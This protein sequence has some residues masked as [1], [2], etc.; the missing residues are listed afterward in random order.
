MSDRRILLVFA[1]PDDESFA[2]GITIAKYAALPNTQ[3][4]LLCA[5]RGEAGKP[6]N[7]PICTV[8]ELPQVREQE[9]LEASRILGID[10]VEILD[11]QDKQVDTVPIEELV[12]QITAA[13]HRDQP[14]VVITFAP[15]G[16]SGHPDHR[17][18][19]EAT[20]VAVQTIGDSSVRKLYHVTLPSTEPFIGVK[21]IHT[22]P[23]DVITTKI[24]CEECV[25]TVAHALLAHR[26]QHLSVDRVFPGIRQG[27]YTHV[28]SVNYYILAWHNIPDYV[29]SDKETDLFSGIL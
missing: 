22:D 18:I 6:G 14:D 29:L 8:E 7:P 1:H 4:F 17:R 11:Y 10:S 27:D 19:S 15:H 24:E 26:T 20:T 23:L 13:I 25:E 28:R 21:N 12:G 9:L 16:I 2:T 5:T 3:L